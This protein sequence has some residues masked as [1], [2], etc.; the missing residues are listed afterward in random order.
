MHTFLKT[1]SII[2]LLRILQKDLFSREVILNVFLFYKILPFS[3][4]II[5]NRIQLFKCLESLFSQ[6]LTF[7]TE[8]STLLCKL[9]NQAKN[10]PPLRSPFFAPTPGKSRVPPVV[11]I[12]FS[13]ADGQVFF[14]VCAIFS[15]EL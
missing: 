3:V 15:K 12:R 10:T 1:S 7:S 2:F 8:F 4:Y 5:F 14:S 11:K 9:Q 13:R 6:L